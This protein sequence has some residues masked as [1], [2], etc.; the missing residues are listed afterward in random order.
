MQY[1]RLQPISIIFSP[2]ITLIQ[3]YDTIQQNLFIKRNYS[4][5]FSRIDGKTLSTIRSIHRLINDKT[6]IVDNRLPNVPIKVESTGV[7]F[8]KH[9]TVETQ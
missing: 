6:C 4:L 1:L 7:I 5:Q 2:G 9:F 3:F 8:S